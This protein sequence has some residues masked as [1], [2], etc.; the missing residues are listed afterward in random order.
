MRFVNI[1]FT[2]THILILQ[3]ENI[4]PYISVSIGL[5]EKRALMSTDSLKNLCQE[6]RDLL[7]AQK[8]RADE[9]DHVSLVAVYSVLLVLAPLVILIDLLPVR[10][11][12]H[13][14][15]DFRVP[16]QDSRG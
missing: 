9:H 2:K 3:I 5:Y 4:S 1:K 14:F 13:F 8:S 11:L 7:H 16:P 15:V 10:K 6:S 12:E